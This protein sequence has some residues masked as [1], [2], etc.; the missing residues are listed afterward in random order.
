MKPSKELEKGKCQCTLCR[1]DVKGLA[2]DV[3]SYVHAIEKQ[4]CNP[5]KLKEEHKPKNCVDC[6]IGAGGLNAE[7]VGAVLAE[8]PRQEKER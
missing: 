4:C 7:A 8:I 3:V 1:G 6:S 2:L 5:C